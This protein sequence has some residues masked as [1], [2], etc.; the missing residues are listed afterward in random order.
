MKHEV[1]DDYYNP[2]KRHER[3]QDIEE[4]FQTLENTKKDSDINNIHQNKKEK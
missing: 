1:Y 3:P 2:L 4:F